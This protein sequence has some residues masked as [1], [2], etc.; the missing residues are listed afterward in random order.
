MTGDWYIHTICN[1][2]DLFSLCPQTNNLDT[3]SSP[4][5]NCWPR[6]DRCHLLPPIRLHLVLS[7]TNSAIAIRLVNTQETVCHCYGGPTPSRGAAHVSNRKGP[8]AMIR[9]SPVLYGVRMAKSQFQRQ[10]SSM[11]AVI[12][13]DAVPTIVTVERPIPE[14]QQRLIKVAAAGL[15]R[16]DILQVQGK[17]PPPPGASEILGLEVSGYLE[18]G[19][20]VCALLSSGAFAEYVAVPGS[21]I[22][23]L[24]LPANNMSPISLAAIPEGFLAAHHLLFQVGAFEERQSV[25]VH[26]AASGVG[27]SLIQLAAL[28]PG[29]RVIASAGSA[30]KL[31]VC[32]QLGA[33]HLINYK[34]ES[35]SDKSLQY[36]SGVGVDLVLDCVGAS[37][38]KENVKSIRADGR[39][40]LY[41]LLSGAKHPDLN[42]AAL[43]GKRVQL[44]STTLRGRSTK[45]K[46]DL[47]SDFTSRHASHFA[48]GALRPV[49]HKVFR[50]LDSVGSAMEYMS[51]NTNIGKIVVDI[52][53]HN[54]S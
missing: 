48:S 38:F 4:I 49:V 37:M 12:A 51:T 26:A 14:H 31:D 40:V 28:V 39:W 53:T 18:D 46:A 30:E 42:L 36:T 32:K 11:R 25:L 1:E 15:N 9:A 10:F 16:A 24:P 6:G 29:A 33:H 52:S 7:Q 34:E 47:I 23:R 2:V 54:E 5:L 44:L 43:L 20:L 8:L 21:A 45:Y 50:G 19:S 35:I 41:G 17:Y 3:C 22:L 13:R 27:T